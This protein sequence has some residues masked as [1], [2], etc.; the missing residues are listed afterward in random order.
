MSSHPLLE[1]LVT[2]HDAGRLVP[3]LG[4]GMSRPACPDWETFVAALERQAAAAV[5][6]AAFEPGADGD[7]FLVERAQRAILAL[8]RAAG[9]GLT[10]ALAAALD[11]AG[12]GVPEQTAALARLYWPL[13]LTINYDDFYLAETGGRPRVLGRTPEHCQRVLSSL[14]EPAEPLLWAIHG[15]LGGQARWRSGVPPPP[16]PERELIV[17]HAEYRRVVHAE[18]HFRRAFAELFRSRSLLFLGCGL[19]DPH[20]L[21]LFEEVLALTGPTPM[22]HYAVLFEEDRSAQLAW[23]LRTRFNIT[24]IQ[25]DTHGELV[26]FLQQLAGEIARPRPRLSG[27]SV[28][29]AEPIDGTPGAAH[30]LE[31]VRGPLPVDRAR[32]A[33]EGG[34]LVV[35]AGL[36]PGPVMSF[37]QPIREAVAAVVGARDDDELRRRVIPPPPRDAR[38]VQLGDHPVFAAIA[39]DR[40]AQEDTKDARRIQDA[41]REVLE[42]L[43]PRYRTLHCQVLAASTHSPYPPRSALAHMLRAFAAWR[44]GPTARIGTRLVI[45]AMDPELL[46]ELA[47]GRLDVL[48]LINASDVRF[49]IEV[50]DAD[51]RIDRELRFAPLATPLAALAADVF[52]AEGSWLVS[53]EPHSRRGEGPVPVAQ[54]FGETL[55]QLGLLHGSTLRFSRAASGAQRPVTT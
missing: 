29:M 41:M 3:F 55:E 15:Y 16:L 46:A 49:W 11:P 14:R 47:S 54:K 28:R 31:I 22:P 36:D 38:V 24:P 9:S 40:T 26:T 18:V 30:D 23:S 43:A 44:A 48:E 39:R 52:S 4:A 42:A 19:S 2:A 10:H 25:L 7:R 35:S 50:Q 32:L 21:A 45:H 53:V 17:G 5:P 1:R 6:G 27:W 8:R 34:C 37:S 33:E 12:R 13:V 51:G 20:L